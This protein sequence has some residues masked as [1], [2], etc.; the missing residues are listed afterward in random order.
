MQCLTDSSHEQ[1]R[2]RWEQLL[3]VC[4]IAVVFGANIIH[5][6]SLHS[7]YLAAIFYRLRRVVSCPG[8][9]FSIMTLTTGGFSDIAPASAP[10]YS[11]T[12]VE[13]V[14]GQFY[15]A[16]VAQAIKPDGRAV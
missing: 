11:L 3:G 5:E 12:W 7:W 14:F 15:I 6:L 16:V 4:L 9:Y 13:S 10:V 1:S 2:R 8:N